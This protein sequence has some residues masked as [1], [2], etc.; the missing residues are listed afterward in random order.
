MLWPG[1]IFKGG[2][3]V[4]LCL[5]S[6]TLMAQSSG[7][8]KAKKLYKQKEYTAACETYSTSLKANNAGKKNLVNA[9]N[10][11]LLFGQPDVG[12][13]FIRLVVDNE[14]RYDEEVIFYHAY[15]LHTLGRL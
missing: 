2:L 4:A 10:A 11:W 12:Y 15:A 6:A 7:L 3:I 9:G 14:N 1:N 8:K 13:E 5:S